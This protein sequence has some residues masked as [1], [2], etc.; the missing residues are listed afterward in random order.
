MH[1]GDRIEQANEN[2]GHY[3]RPLNPSVYVQ[4]DRLCLSFEAFL[5]VRPYLTLPLAILY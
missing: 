1:L 3:T 5:C 4:F 2:E